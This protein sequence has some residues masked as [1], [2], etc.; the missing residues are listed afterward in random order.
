MLCEKKKIKELFTD[1]NIS[2]SWCS[3]KL[4]R[5]NSIVD[6]FMIEAYDLQTLKVGQYFPNDGNDYTT[7]VPEYPLLKVW[8]FYGKW[9]NLTCAIDKDTCCSWYKMLLLNEWFYDT[10]DNNEFAIGC[11][12]VRVKAN[13]VKEWIM[14]YTRHLWHFHTLED[15][16]E[17]DSVTLS[18]L[19]LYMQNVYALKETSDSNTAQYYY[20]RFLDLMKKANIMYK[21][22]L[23]YVKPGVALNRVFEQ[24]MSF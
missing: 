17:I 10:I 14:V 9:C 4:A 19:R 18:L 1:L 2:D 20:N 13:W 6:E 3:S 22:S 15:E 23:K 24:P 12:D 11:H 5:F 8:N 16:I 21:N 7:I